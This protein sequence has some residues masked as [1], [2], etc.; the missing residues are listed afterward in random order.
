MSA[1]QGY[2]RPVSR[3]RF[4]VVEGVEGAGKTTQ[5]R[6]LSSWLS[7]VG[8]EHVTAREPGGTEVGEAIRAVLLEQRAGGMPAETELLLMLGAR[9]VFVREVVEPALRSGRVVIADR[10]ELSTFAYQGFGRGLDLDEVRR[11]NRFATGGRSPDLTVVLDVPV[12]DGARRQ[13]RDGSD[14]DRIEQEGAVFLQK[15]RDGYRAL[16]DGSPDVR[17]IDGRGE[18]DAVHAQLTTLLTES[19]P[20]TFSGETGS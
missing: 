8:V 9:S 12:A 18:V 15:V 19:F 14:R 2:R 20:E 4:I 11:L 6:L 5:T 3:A 16:A 17:L 13:A 7:R 10:F 1:S